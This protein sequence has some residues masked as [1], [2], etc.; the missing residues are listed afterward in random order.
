M[1]RLLP[2]LREKKRYVVF[3]VLSK[4]S[5]PTKT[6]LNAIQDAFLSFSGEHRA[7]IAGIYLPP[8]LYNEKKQQGIVR[9]NH[10]LVDLIRAS[11]CCMKQIAAESAIVRSIAVSGSLK[12]AKQ[13]IFAA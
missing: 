1:M 11:F 7:A 3:E 4:K 13:K 10:T 9:V 6:A 8:N 12:K 2:S 5:I